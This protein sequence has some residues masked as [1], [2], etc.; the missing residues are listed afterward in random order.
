MRSNFLFARSMALALM[1]I[2]TVACISSDTYAANRT[3]TPTTGLTAGKWGTAQIYATNWNSTA[4]PVTNPTPDDTAIFSS[5]SNR[6]ITTQPNTL[7]IKNI[8]I[9]GSGNNTFS[10][11]IGASIVISG[12]GSPAIA[13]SNTSAGIQLF[14]TR[15][16][17]TG[18]TSTVQS[19]A[20]A[21]NFGGGGVDLAGNYL[22]GIGNISQSSLGSSV[23]GATY[24][25]VSGTQTVTFDSGSGGNVGTMVVNGGRVSADG[26]S[27]TDLTVSG[28]TYAG[29]GTYKNVLS[30]SGQVFI[31]AGE[32][33]NTTNFVQTAGGSLTMNVNDDLSSSQVFGNYQLGGAFE[34]DAALLS[35]SVYPLGTKWS[36]FQG[37]N[38]TSG[39]ASAANAGSNF[40]SFAMSNGSAQSP[41]YGTFTRYGQE[42]LSPR[43]TDGT[44]LV[45]QAATGNLVVVPEPSTMVFAGLGVAMSGWTMWKKRRLSKLL[46]AKAG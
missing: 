10:N 16:V 23:A 30:S 35:S 38:F 4:N 46:A 12:S 24:E 39:S 40:S 18:A 43:A 42:W 36:L 14:N 31:D 33:L 37:V 15:V 3:W 44:F 27:A 25:V 32:V 6:T 22:K 26:T 41:Y 11:T 45:F 2:G 7:S 34:L 9:G 17:F 8:V 1:A 19:T 5:A 21:L 20:G 28:G 29:G 13:I